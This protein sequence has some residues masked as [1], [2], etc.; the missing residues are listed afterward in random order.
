MKLSEKQVYFR[1]MFAEF[2]IFAIKHGYDF[3][4]GEV[5]RRADLTCPYC[6]K[7]INVQ[8]ALIKMRLSCTMFSKHLDKLAFDIFRFE[9]GKFITKI[10]A[11]KLLAL[12]WKSLDSKNRWG[13]DFEGFC[14]P[15]HFEYSG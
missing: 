12:F 14:D 3:S 13:G 9:N 15:F 11:Y 10:K 8:K 4:I 5:W 1:N 6:S 2:L 7:A